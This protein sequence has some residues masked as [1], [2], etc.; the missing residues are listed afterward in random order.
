MTSSLYVIE[1]IERLGW[2]EGG[3]KNGECE[4]KQ[5]AVEKINAVR[6][7]ERQE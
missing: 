2:P 5:E 7:T 1:G 4:L 3:T 6:G